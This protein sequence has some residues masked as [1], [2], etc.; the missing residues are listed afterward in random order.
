MSAADDFDVEPDYTT[1]APAKVRSIVDNFKREP[2]KMLSVLRQFYSDTYP[3]EVGGEPN[4][5]FYEPNEDVWR[6]YNPKGLDFG[7]VVGFGRELAQTGG[8]I[9]GGATAVALGQVPPLTAV[10]DEAVTVP[11]FA[12]AGSTLTGQAYD[13]ITSALLPDPFSETLDP[14]KQ[15]LG[16]ATGFAGEAA[17]GPVLGK[18]IATVPQSAKSAGEGIIRRGLGV[19]QQ[20]QERGRRALADA[21]NLEIEGL[22]AGMISGSPIVQSITARILQTPGG[23]SPL[24]R[25]WETLRASL[26]DAATTVAKRWSKRGR[27]SGEQIG[28]IVAAG[29]R[30]AHKRFQEQEDKLYKA[31]YDLIPE[32]AT[33]K[34][35]AMQALYDRLTAEVATSPEV[36]GRS[37]KK[38]LAEIEMQL[39]DTA[40]TGGLSVARFRKNRTLFRERYLSADRLQTDATQDEL[41]YLG[42]VYKAFTADMKGA[43]TAIDE[44]NPVRQEALKALNIADRYV[45][46][47]HHSDVPVLREI[48]RRAN[49]G[50]LDV[51]KLLNRDVKE[52]SEGIRNI[53]RQLKQE[54]KDAVTASLV[55]RLGYISPAGEGAAEELVETTFSPA[56]FLSQYQAI[57][58]DAKNAI[59]GQ[60]TYR[61]SLDTL[62]KAMRDVTSEIKYE[63]PPKTGD[64]IAL[65]ATFAPLLTPIGGGVSMKAAVGATAGLIVAPHIAAR[66]VTNKKFINWLVDA[67]PKMRKN[68]NSAS[69]HL[70]RLMEISSRD[71]Q[72]R[73]DA[74]AYIAALPQTLMGAATQTQDASPAEEATAS[75]LAATELGVPEGWREKAVEASDV[76][77]EEQMLESQ[78]IQDLVNRMDEAR[79]QKVLD[80]VRPR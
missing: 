34:P 61:K 22:T 66:L 57:S 67:A 9:V 43:V 42:D 4:F 19:G 25:N 17:L 23:K 12:A 39:R 20:A 5:I 73:E 79:R 55:K 26:A 49:K 35:N 24:V 53:Y 21:A 27:R 52:S 69:L 64:I 72:F 32:G 7:D 6:V 41:R 58:S 3:L 74:E 44:A 10:P 76:R 54:E 56:K 8:G 33:V 1:G 70:G 65:I 46:R 59:F 31:A 14:A 29:G 80:A 13:A 11:A 50:S 16:G 28:E 60:G 78:A 2:E 37:A 62:S 75:W 63:N 77:Q 71:M 48:E 68:P 40:V 45:R 30:A 38:A 36:A 15:V 47:R 51:F 18:I